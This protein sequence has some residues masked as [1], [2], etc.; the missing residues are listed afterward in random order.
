MGANFDIKNNEKHKE[1]ESLLLSIENRIKKIKSVEDSLRQEIAEL[2]ERKYTDDGVSSEPLVREMK[3]KLKEI[4]ISKVK[5]QRTLK[6]VNKTIKIRTDNIIGG[7]ELNP[8]A[9]STMNERISMV[10]LTS[11]VSHKTKN[12]LSDSAKGNI[13]SFNNQSIKIQKALTRV[14]ELTNQINSEYKEAR[15]KLL[16]QTSNQQAISEQMASFSMPDKMS[17][18][19]ELSTKMN[20]ITHHNYGGLDRTGQYL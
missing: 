12:K 15:L 8:E 13:I 9:D 5:Y 1:I 18:V 4:L 16:V 17:A 6:L 11:I 7:S 19:I 14:M 20:S 10:N 2:K 3:G